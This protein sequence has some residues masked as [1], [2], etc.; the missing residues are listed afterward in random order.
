MSSGYQVSPA[1]GSSSGMFEQKSAFASRAQTAISVS[2]PNVLLVGRPGSWASSLIKFL[3]KSG[4]ELFFVA[5]QTATPEYLKKVGYSLILLDSTV[6][7]EH[8]RQLTSEL[9]GSNVSIFY[10]FP[11]EN[12]CWWLPTLRYGQNCHGAP[13][14]RRNELLFEFERIL[15]DQPET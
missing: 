4:A 7:P 11:V 14:F 10:T 6:P 5:P 13:A 9:V 15:R 3:E 8:R 1:S 12:G 2:C